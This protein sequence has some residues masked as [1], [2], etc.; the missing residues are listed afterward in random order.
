MKKFTLLFIAAFLAVQSYPQIDAF[1]VVGKQSENLSRKFGFGGFLKLSQPINEGADEL[2]AE[3]GLMSIDDG[4]IGFMPIKAGYRYT[5][6]RSGYGFYFEPQAGFAYGFDYEEK[7]NGFVGSG[8]L[9]YLFQPAA[10]IRFDIALRSENIF[11]NI[12]TFN[13]IGLRLA[14]NFSFKRRE[15]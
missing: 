2:T 3:L 15:E 12:G 4:D 8:N 5:F 9:G 6:N 13:F 1:A 11:T 10:G 14:H 7:R